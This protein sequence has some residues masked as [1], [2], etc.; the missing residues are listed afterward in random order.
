MPRR[1]SAKATGKAKS[2]ADLKGKKVPSEWVQQTSD[3]P[4][5]RLP[6]RRRHLAERRGAGARGQRGARG[7]RLQAGKLDLLFFAV[8][9]PKVQEV[10][11]AVGGLRVLPADAV[12]GAEQRMKKIRPEYFSPR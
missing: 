3:P 9:A 2:I 10:A 12:P 7:G 4:H 11:A 8:G 6:Q 1:A 5:E